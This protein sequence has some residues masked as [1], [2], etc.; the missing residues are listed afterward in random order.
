MR[1]EDLWEPDD[2]DVHDFLDIQEG[3]KSLGD[4]K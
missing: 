4:G 3:M 1:K 2:E